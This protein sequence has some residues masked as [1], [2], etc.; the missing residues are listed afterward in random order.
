M[1]APEESDDISCDD[2]STNPLVVKSSEAE[3]KSKSKSKKKSLLESKLENL[4]SSTMRRV[5]STN[6]RLRRAGSSSGLQ[7][8]KTPSERAQRRG[9][10]G[11]K[12][13]ISR[14]LLSAGSLNKTSKSNLFKDSTSNPAN[15]N[16]DGNGNGIAN[17]SWKPI[18]LEP[19]VKKKE[20]NPKVDETEEEGGDTVTPLMASKPFNSNNRKSLFKRAASLK[21]FG[22]SK[23]TK[24][25]DG[26]EA[27]VSNKTTTLSTTLDS[28]SINN[29]PARTRFFQKAAS[30]RIGKSSKWDSFDEMSLNEQSDEFSIHSTNHQPEPSA[31]PARPE[32]LSSL[33][34]SLRRLNDLSLVAQNKDDDGGSL[35][36]LNGHGSSS[37]FGDSS[38]CSIA[39][40]TLWR[41]NS[42]EMR[43][44]LQFAPSTI[45]TMLTEKLNQNP[46][47]LVKNITNP[48]IATTTD[49]TRQISDQQP[50]APIGEASTPEIELE[51]K[52]EPISEHNDDGTNPAME[53]E[54]S[55]D[56]PDSAELESKAEPP[57]KF[58]RTK[59]KS[60]GLKPRK[61]KSSGKKPGE[62]EENDDELG[63]DSGHSKKS[64][65][66]RKKRKG[67]KRQNT[68]PFEEKKVD[69]E[70]EM[71]EEN[72]VEEGSNSKRQ[73]GDESEHKEE[74]EFT[75]VE[76]EPLPDES[77]K[78]AK[79]TVEE[80]DE[81]QSTDGDSEIV[82]LTSAKKDDND[83]SIDKDESKKSLVDESTSKLPSTE[84]IAKSQDSTEPSVTAWVPPPAPVRSNRQSKSRSKS[85]KN[86]LLKNFAPSSPRRRREAGSRSP[87]LARAVSKRLS[88]GSDNPKSN[89]G[90]DSD[91]DE[92]S[93]ASRRKTRRTTLQK[94][95]SIFG[96]KMPGQK[97]RRRRSLGGSVMKATA[98]KGKG[99]ISS[100]LGG[101]VH[102]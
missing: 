56:L 20:P 55:S 58:K 92:S 33:G 64:R 42:E 17:A 54:E 78:E 61:K 24:D 77:E 41:E 25:S 46:P 74:I 66:V 68:S 69:G 23:S 71:N 16:G 12:M 70:S 95:T 100:F 49:T 60:K 39:S 98:D 32:G 2:S 72:A 11:S 45:A 1:L 94:H 96:D 44:G 59:S 27:D 21:R 93:R 82:S 35:S 5:A 89:A 63:K 79:G 3:T 87:R 13:S 18:N 6:G 48:T 85:P 43:P 29:K 91:D 40:P 90:E 76:E 73:E 51:E 4:P 15:G 84:S 88:T 83:A 97:T 36:Q 8:R 65:K 53:N 75:E 37:R 38:S 101:S 34:Q 26:S 52:K 57:K 10:T 47:K 19:K 80:A 28:S 99:Y 50:S 14:S 67:G 22:L 62:L 81:I 30:M 86:P 7:L 31:K 9:S 102:K